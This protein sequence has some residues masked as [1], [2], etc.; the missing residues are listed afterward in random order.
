VPE[1]AAPEELLIELESGTPVQGR[2][3]GPGG[4]TRTEEK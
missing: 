2:V 3:L 1:D 4:T